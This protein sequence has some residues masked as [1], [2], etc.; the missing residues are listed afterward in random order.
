[1]ASCH[2]FL[3]S[4]P[5]ARDKEKA[6]DRRALDPLLGRWLWKVCAADGYQVI[7]RGR[8]KPA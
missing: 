4:D 5:F 3:P 8:Q 7:T 2:N 6:D 1:M